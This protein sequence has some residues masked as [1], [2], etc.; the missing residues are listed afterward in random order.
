MENKLALAEDALMRSLD[1]HRKSFGEIHPQVAYVMERLAEIYALRGEF[2]LARDYSVRALAVMKSAF[3]EESAAF[4][5]AL[6]NRGTVEQL[7]GIP[8]AAAENYGAALRILE[9]NADVKASHP[10][11]AQQIA[12][13]YALVLKAAHR[14]REAKAASALAK[15][16]RRFI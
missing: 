5:A 9:H 15:S 2:V 1:L 13:R 10:D 12:E 7:A 4:V 16:F 6:V 11:L 3:G 14:D 8:G